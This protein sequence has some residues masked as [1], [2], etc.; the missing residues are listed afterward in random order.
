M[1][2]L[3]T[4]YIFFISIL[5]TIAKS[6]R[7]VLYS[8]TLIMAL[9]FGGIYNC[10][11][12]GMYQMMYNYIKV[13]GFTFYSTTEIGF[14]F[15]VYLCT[16]VGLSYKLFRT[17]IA[18]IGLLLMQKTVL[19]F[20]KKYS[21]VF[22]LYF[23][24]PY[25]LDVIQ[26]RNFLAASIVIFSIRFLIKNTRKGDL[27]YLVGIL[28]AVSIH[29]MAVFFI[30]FIF[31][32]RY[33]VNRLAKIALYIVPVLCV[34]TSTP[35][36]PNIVSSIVGEN[37]AASIEAYFQRAHWGFLL[38]WARQGAITVLA[39]FCYQ[40]LQDK[41]IEE[42]WKV[43]NNVI[44]KLNIYLII[45]CFPLLMFNGNF[46]RLLRP[47]LFLNYIVISQVLYLDAKRGSIYSILAIF[48]TLLYFAMDVLT[49]SNI[50]SVFVPFFQSNSYL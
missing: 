25:M 2:Y 26:I 20:S 34:L 40:F 46:F 1:T 17:L 47:M 30:P 39:Y 16:K 10:S 18:I 35:I 5:N 45:I 33:S 36:I 42:E 8:T 22:I 9:L 11:D 32:K 48:F 19:D 4:L 23:I 15:F 21:L 50:T 43:L 24:Y 41:D 14:T 38:L 28:I 31:F 6:N 3:A 49:S 13:N 27:Q 12:D 7:V 37:L 29:Y 44:I